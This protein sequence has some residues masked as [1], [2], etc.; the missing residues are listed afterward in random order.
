MGPWSP[1]GSKY[2]FEHSSVDQRE[3]RVYNDVDGSIEP[4]PFRGQPSFS[5]DG[6]T[7]VWAE[8]GE[9]LELRMIESRR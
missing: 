9:S 8:A 3:F 7:V 2:Y 1:D 5:Q 4:S 6:T